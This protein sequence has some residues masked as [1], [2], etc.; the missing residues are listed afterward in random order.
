[1]PDEKKQK[2]KT[3][4]FATAAEKDKFTNQLIDFVRANR[5][6][7]DNE[8]EDF[9][10]NEK[11]NELWSDFIR[12]FYNNSVNMSVNSVKRSLKS[13]KDGWNRENTKIKSNLSDHGQE[14]NGEEI[15]VWRYYHA[16]SFLQSSTSAEEEI[17]VSIDKSYFYDLTAEDGTSANNDVNS[18]H[19]P[20]ILSS[21]NKVVLKRKLSNEL[22]RSSRRMKSL[23][24]QDDTSNLN[25]RSRGSYNESD[26]SR[27]ASELN[28]INRKMDTLIQSSMMKHDEQGNYSFAVSLVDSLKLIK[29]PKTLMT[30]KSDILKLISE[31]IS[32]T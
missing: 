8:H 12:F 22:K 1:M 32:E 13:L 23:N 24:E 3:V 2:A 30:V 4:Q 7:W 14:I 11:K 25:G 31:N 9:K 20:Q 21:K 17:V 28:Q 29:N 19:I 18:D 26:D 6:L 10:N 15:K 27:L 16:L 5:C